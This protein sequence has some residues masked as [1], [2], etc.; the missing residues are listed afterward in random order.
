MHF[1]VISDFKWRFT[2]LLLQCIDYGV[3][4]VGGIAYTCYRNRFRG[5][6]EK[7]R[8]AYVAL[9]YFLSK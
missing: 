8:Q 2:V 7:V 1:L 3:F 9:V 6:I 5:E 4:V